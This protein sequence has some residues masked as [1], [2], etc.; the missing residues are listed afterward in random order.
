MK[1]DEIRKY[2][3]LL[4]WCRLDFDENLYINKKQMNESSFVKT[5]SKTFLR[6][7]M[8][9]ELSIFDFLKNKIYSTLIQTIIKI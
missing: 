3:V 1:R 7:E 6:T 2:R 5:S 8:I 4:Y 9:V